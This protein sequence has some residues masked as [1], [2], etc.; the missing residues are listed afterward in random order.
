[1]M[2]VYIHK[3]IFFVVDSFLLL[4]VIATTTMNNRKA[5]IAINIFDDFVK[6]YDFAIYY[7]LKQ[8]FRICVYIIH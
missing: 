5:I 3:Y 4:F 6:K 1:M 2:K 8:R 7:G